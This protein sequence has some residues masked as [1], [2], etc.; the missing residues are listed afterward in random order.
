VS[1]ARLPRRLERLFW[2]RVEALGPEL[3]NRVTQAWRDT[4]SGG[5]MAAYHEAVAARQAAHDAVAAALMAEFDGNPLPSELA[6]Q[7]RLRLEAS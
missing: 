6:E 3:G 5:T 1:V 7:L 2:E 4:W